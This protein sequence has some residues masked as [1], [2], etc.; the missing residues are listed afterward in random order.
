MITTTYI[1]DKTTGESKRVFR[2]AKNGGGI[3]MP[4]RGSFRNK[5]FRRF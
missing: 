2:R 5:I 3:T 1:I 4:G